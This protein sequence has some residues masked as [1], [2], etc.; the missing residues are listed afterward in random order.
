MGGMTPDFLTQLAPAHAPPPPGWWPLAPIWWALVL[1]AVAFALLALY[2]YRRPTTRLRRAA[3]SELAQLAAMGGESAELARRLEN[4]VRRYAVARFG[5][6]TVAQLSGARWIDFV[7]AHGGADWRG[8]PGAAL[9]R[10]A[11]GGSPHAEHAPWISGA[12][13]FFKARS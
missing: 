8:V 7:V 11:F 4:L 9:L 5:R 1:L 3:L 10:A 2:R 13:A 12:R 6:D